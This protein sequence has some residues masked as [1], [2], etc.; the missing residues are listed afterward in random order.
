M[1]RSLVRA[2][3]VATFC[4][5]ICTPAFAQNLSFLPRQNYTVGDDPLSAAFGDVNGD[6]RIDMVV[7]N[8]AGNGTGA[9]P[10][11]SVMLGNVSRAFT[12]GGTIPLTA[13]T[14]HLRSAELNVD[15]LL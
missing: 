14:Y 6:G 1:S 5:H 11:L 13:P 7:A 4:I 9:P 10:T 3:L 15:G 2:F 12:L 8:D